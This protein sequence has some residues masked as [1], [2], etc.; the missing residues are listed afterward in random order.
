MKC[1]L[2][3]FSEDK[4]R[5]KKTNVSMNYCHLTIKMSML[6]FLLTCPYQSGTA[7]RGAI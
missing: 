2:M 7:N 6:L 3:K 1:F 4:K 5:K